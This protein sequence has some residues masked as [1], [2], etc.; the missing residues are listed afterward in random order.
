MRNMGG[1]FSAIALALVENSKMQAFQHVLSG[2]YQTRFHRTLSFIEFTP[3]EG[4]G[5]IH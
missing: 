5:I 4:A 1:G 3:S 2:E